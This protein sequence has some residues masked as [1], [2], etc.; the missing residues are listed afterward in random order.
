LK[1]VV[2]DTGPILHLAEAGL[3]NLLQN[4][5]STV[6]P[7]GVYKELCLVSTQ[8]FVLPDWLKISTLT[9]DN[10]KEARI[11][12]HT[13]G[14]HVGECEAIV[15]T[16]QIN[17]DWL[18]TDDAAAR[19]CAEMMSI[20]VHGALGVVLWNVAV[21]ILNRELSLDALQRLRN[22]SLWI[23]ESIYQS[24]VQAVIELTKKAIPQ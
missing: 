19:Y 5:G 6:I 16:R 8:Q 21:G 9:D 17:A 10:G 3:L 18:L 15:L 23:S 12:S 7:A 2:S 1:I 13:A 14:L 24:A 20:E 4:I 22:S 11:L